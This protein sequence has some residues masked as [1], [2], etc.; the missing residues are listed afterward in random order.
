MAL[1]PQL[2][3]QITS[4]QVLHHLTKIKPNSYVLK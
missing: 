2:Q 1:I 4:L 3:N